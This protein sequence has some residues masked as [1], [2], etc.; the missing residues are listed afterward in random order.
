MDGKDTASGGYE[1]G[2]NGKIKIPRKGG[3]EGEGR[4]FRRKV[5]KPYYI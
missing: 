3:K 2:F 5:S 1:E 4:R